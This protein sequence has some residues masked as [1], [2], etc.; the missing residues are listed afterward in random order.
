MTCARFRTIRTTCTAR[1][2][3]LALINAMILHARVSPP[4]RELSISLRA[5]RWTANSLRRDRRGLRLISLSANRAALAL[6]PTL[7]RARA[8]KTR[9]PPARNQ[10][11]GG[12]RSRGV[13]HATTDQPR[14]TNPRSDGSD[15]SRRRS[16]QVNLQTQTRVP[17]L[18]DHVSQLV[19]ADNIRPSWASCNDGLQPDVGW[20][21]RTLGIQRTRN[22]G[23]RVE[24]LGMAGVE[25]RL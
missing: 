4:A 9:S 3:S 20:L 8:Y 14:V 19:A 6:R 2:L 7:H 22:P 24:R 25:R 21:K 23:D 18:V 10:P 15:Q 17:R 5:T 11:L 13:L 12:S 16:L 1:A